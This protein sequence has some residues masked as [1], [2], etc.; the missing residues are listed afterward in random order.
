MSRHVAL[1]RAINVAGHNTVAMSDLREMLEALGFS[2]V[3]SLLQ[4]GNLVFRSD[5]R[6]GAA[7][8]RLLEAETAERLKVAADYIVRSA[9]EWATV[10]GRNPFHKEAE[11]APGRLVAVF[12]KSAAPAKGVDALRAAIRGPETIHGDGKELF[13]VYPDGI[14]RSKL[15]G[16]LIESKLGIRGT[17][18]NWNTVLKIA[19][20]LGDDR[21]P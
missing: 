4:S 3:K 12:L 19:A 15:T 6:T 8:E 1:L 14:G 10:V 13:V 2:E 18:R 21:K 17:A 16:A 7:M 5:R 20:Q 9:A 11:T